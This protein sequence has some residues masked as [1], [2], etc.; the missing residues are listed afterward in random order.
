MRRREFIT[1]VGGGAAAWPIAARAQQPQMPVVGFLNSRSR[2]DFSDDD[3][4]EFHQG[5]SQLGYV[6]GR[7]LLIEYRWADNQYARLPQLVADLIR[8]SVAVIT[9][10]APAAAVA[11]AATTTTP[12]VFGAEVDP[13][14][15]GLVASLNRPGGNLTGV[16]GMGAEIGPKRLELLREL[17]PAATSVA[18]LV[19]S[20]NPLADVLSMDTEAAARTLGLQLHVM[21][22]STEIDFDTVFTILARR[23]VDGLVITPAAFFNSQRE[24]LGHLSL[25]HGVPAIFQSR[26]FAAAGGLMSYGQSNTESWRMIGTYTGRILKG[27]KPADLPVQQATRI[28]LIINMKTAKALGIEVPPMLLACANEVIE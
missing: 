11:K 10:N 3:M 6:E 1:L 8:R 14:A 18:L 12:I 2:D 22:A 17:L 25:R 4:R 13:V 5:L 27:E 15:A 16:T 19:N 23:R 28:D 24:Q 26:A 21:R 9:A 20:T 7:S